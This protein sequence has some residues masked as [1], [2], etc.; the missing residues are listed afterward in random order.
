[1]E[2]KSH[3]LHV[4]SLDK[5]IPPFIDLIREEVS[6][7][8]N[9]FSIRGDT[10]RF[11]Y[12]S[13]ADTKYRKNNIRAYLGLLLDMYR[14]DKIVLHGLFDNRL[15]AVLF[16]NPWLLKKCYWVLWGGDYF[17]YKKKKETLQQKLVE[18]FRHA[19][20]SRIGHLVTYM[21]GSVEIVRDW[22]HARG[23][24][25]ECLAYTS[26]TVNVA[27]TKPKGGYN[28]PIKVLIGNSANPSNR[29]FDILE[30]LTPYAGED[31][32]VYAPLSYGDAEYGREV[33]EKAHC[34]L[35]DK[36]I[37]MTNLIP[38]GEYQAFLDDIDIALFNHN[39]QQAMGTIINLLGMGKKV[40]MPSDIASWDFLASKGIEVYD[41][42][43]FSGFDDNFFS[44]AN[45]DKISAY[46]SRENLVR[47]WKGILDD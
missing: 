9:F 28:R 8:S 42:Q 18:F 39:R 3:N 2:A 6:G 36:F 26:N 27:D 34:I 43:D 37:P 32:M 40:Y 24:F 20:I 30:K 25:H 21:P 15:V 1:M 33:I 17:S 11:P 12:T 45:Q 19:V 14:S 13:G 35:G 7:S 22:Y 16:F 5:F 38:H 44:A 10:H 31:L 41:V 29:H 46:F 23:Q 47:Q 4:C